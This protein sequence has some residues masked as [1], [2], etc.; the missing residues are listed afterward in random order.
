MFKLDH[1]DHVAISVTD[2]D[3]SIAWYKE[4]LGLERRHPEWDE[5]AMLCA[6]PSCVA[7]FRAEGDSPQAAPG[8]DT[9]AMRHFA[10]HV[11]REN[12]GAAQDELRGRGIEFAFE[13]HGAAHSIYIKDPDGH[14]IEITTEA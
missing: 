13:D 3:A 10:F 11:D 12:F 2:L 8:Y 4:T 14:R 7:L 5:P 1:L 6:G 9:L